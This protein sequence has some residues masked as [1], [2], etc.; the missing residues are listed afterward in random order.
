MGAAFYCKKFV[1][2][3]FKSSLPSIEEIERKLNQ[4]DEENRQETR[5]YTFWRNRK[6]LCK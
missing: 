5:L 1:P 2:E 3:D 4:E 6:K